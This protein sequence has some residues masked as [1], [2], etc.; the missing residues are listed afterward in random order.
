[1]ILFHQVNHLYIYIGNDPKT[2]PCGTPAVTFSYDEVCP[3]KT[4]LCWHP[5]K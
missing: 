3:F 4:N 5:V 1:M 2:E